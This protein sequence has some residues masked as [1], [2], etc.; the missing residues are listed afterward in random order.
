MRPTLLLTFALA[1]RTDDPEPADG[2]PDDT[3][4]TTTPPTVPTLTTPT[5]PLPRCSPALSIEPDGAAVDPLDLLQLSASGG[6]GDYVWDVAPGGLGS[7]SPF[8][9]YLAP[10]DPAVETVVLTDRGCEGSAEATISVGQPFEVLPATATVTPGT[11]FTFEVEGGTGAHSCS[12][13]DAG[14]GGALAGCVYTAGDDAGLDRI[15]VVDDGTGERREA[16]IT[17]DPGAVWRPWGAGGWTLPVGHPFAARAEGGSGELELSVSS[18]PFTADGDVLTADGP[19]AGEV[20]VRDRFAGTEATVAVVGVEPHLSPSA[21]FGTQ[22][23]HGRALALGDV[24]GD[25]YDDAAFGLAELHAGAYTSGAAVVWRGGPGGLGPAPAWTWAGTTSDQAVGRALAHADLDGDGVKDLVVGADGDDYGLSNVGTLEVFRGV[26]GGTFEAEPFRLLRGIYASDRFGT[27]I[28]VCDVDGDGVDD[29]AAT[30]YAHEYRSGS[31][32]PNDTGGVMV[33]RGTRVGAGVEYADA[34]TTVT[35]GASVVTGTW[36]PVQSAQLGFL[37]LAGGD[38]DAD[39][40]C[41]LAVAT[42]GDGVF[43]APESYG[44]V[45]VFEG[46]PSVDGTLSDRPVRQYANVTDTNASFGR[47]LALGDVDGD[48]AADLLVG[49]WAWD[50][51]RGGSSGGAFLFLGAS[52]DGRDPLVPV[53]PLE[54]D[55]WVTGR[56]G[57]DYTGLDVAL[58]D[59]DGDGGDDVILGAPRGEAAGGVANAGVARVYAA[60]DVLQGAGADAVDATPWLEVGGT[61]AEEFFGQAVDV[62]GDTDG[63]GELDLLVLAGRSDA[64]GYDVPVAYDAAAGRAPRV[65][66]LPGGPAGHDHGR[67]SVVVDVDGD[68]DR[69]LLVGSPQDLD[70]ARGLFTGRLDAFAGDGALDFDDAPQPFPAAWA[71]LGSSDRAGFA[72]AALDF[73]GDGREDLAVASRTDARPATFGATYT[74]PSGCPGAV[75]SAGSVS[76]YLGTPAGLATAPAFVFYGPDSSA[77]IRVLAG[78]LDHDGDG[79]DDLLVA[80]RDWRVEGGFAIV[81]GRP[82]DPL[83]T[84]VICAADTWYGRLSGDLF[85]QAATAL[86]DLDGDGCDEAAVTAPRDDLVR[87]DQG[88]V[89]IFW[90]YGAACATPGPRITSLALDLASSVVG[91]ALSSGDVDGDGLAD[92]AV[93]SVDWRIAGTRYGGV[94]LAPG[95]WLASL[96]WETAAVGILPEPT[97]LQRLVPPTGGH[98][99]VD[100]PTRSARFGAA[101]AVVRDPALGRDVVAVGLPDGDVGGVRFAGGVLTYAWTADTGDGEPGLDPVPWRVVGGETASPGGAFGETL[102][103]ARQGQRSALLVGSP[104]SSAG[105]VQQGAAWVAPVERP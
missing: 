7:V 6:T 82:A 4:P 18:G 97:T 62:V 35:Y 50:G 74:N 30:A 92:L 66:E 52:W 89:R 86:A 29:V 2:V 33:F 75:S 71:D 77:Q 72:L 19:G 100:G 41:D 70:P 84:T 8:G 51:P 93:T 31:T 99:A 68:G 42:Q 38:V 60:D 13:V 16:T 44:F 53:E 80:G 55:W 95:S 23:L 14:S 79:V 28:A 27:A 1:C 32:Y 103:A 26:P 67:A 102:A 45:Q 101:A 47:D 37:G 83:G 96:P 5:E 94:W 85:G 81:H 88:V 12:L 57:S 49:A 91:E 78:P 43:G 20:R 76:V 73:D 98:F 17:V 64:G 54:A 9:T 15:R 56:E 58:A 39:G 25:G 105:G 3:G 48:G 10:A 59:L 46:L 65:L 104:L 61:V 87:T 69:D 34:P 21:W 40:D 11:T 22:S 36:T 24:D 63:D 90:G